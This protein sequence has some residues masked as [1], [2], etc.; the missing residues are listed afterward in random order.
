M[1]KCLEANN[2]LIFLKRNRNV[3]KQILIKIKKWNLGCYTHR[4]RE[5]TR[6]QGRTVRCGSCR[7]RERLPRSPW[8]SQPE[9]EAIVPAV[10]LTAGG[11]G[12]APT[13]NL[14]ISGRGGCARLDLNTG[15]RGGRAPPWMWISPPE[16][17]EAMVLATAAASTP[18]PAAAPI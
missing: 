5:R 7:W 13:V 2:I 12:G 15:G 4:E 1:I 8:I 3:A 18:H 6:P 11:R 17:Q 9:R 16:G 10:D 14:T